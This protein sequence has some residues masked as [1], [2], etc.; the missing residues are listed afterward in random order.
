M[1]IYSMDSL[2]S[3]LPRKAKT[4]EDPVVF[5]KGNPHSLADGSLLPSGRISF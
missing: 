5:L 2:R 4:L 1:A 3:L